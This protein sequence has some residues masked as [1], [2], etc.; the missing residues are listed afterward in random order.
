[1]K[2][3]AQERWREQLPPYCEFHSS[4]WASH[5]IER[6][7]HITYICEFCALKKWDKAK[8]TKLHPQ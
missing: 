7:G 5:A 8:V 1:M 6:D 3:G 4:V 2:L